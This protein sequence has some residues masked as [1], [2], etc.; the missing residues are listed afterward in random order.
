MGGVNA[1]TLPPLENGD[2]LTRKEFERRYAATI[3]NPKAELIDGVVYLASPTKN[4]HARYHALMTAW[5]AL[6]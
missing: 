5:L 3:G 6:Y 1:T 4:P 2:C